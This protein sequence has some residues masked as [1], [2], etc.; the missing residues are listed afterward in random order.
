MACTTINFLVDG[1]SF[2]KLKTLSISMSAR[3]L[4]KDVEKIPYKTSYQSLCVGIESVY[5]D[6]LDLIKSYFEADKKNGEELYR[7]ERI[8]LFGI[9]VLLHREG[10]ERAFL[11][12]AEGGIDFSKADSETKYQALKA[13]RNEVFR[14]S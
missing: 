4:L 3:Y 5:K 12:A 2:K 9:A 11:S 6:Y 10:V 7:E 1:E 8:V 14:V 13:K